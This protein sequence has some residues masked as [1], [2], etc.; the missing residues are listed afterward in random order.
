[1]GGYWFFSG[2]SCGLLVVVLKEEIRK[3][4]DF[5]LSLSLSLSSLFPLYLG[6]ETMGERGRKRKTHKIAKTYYTKTRQEERN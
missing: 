6:G 2:V 5:S 3:K 1:M 4:L